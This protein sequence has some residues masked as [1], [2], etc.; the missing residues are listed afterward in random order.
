M[1]L[2]ASLKQTSKLST[3]P[4]FEGAPLSMKAS[5]LACEQFALSNHLSDAATQQLTELIRMHCPS[6]EHCAKSTYQLRNQLKFNLEVESK[7]FCS[8]CKEEINEVSKM[9]SKSKCK[10][11]N[12]GVCYLAVL[13]FHSHLH[14]IFTGKIF[15]LCCIIFSCFFFT[16][17]WQEIC[18]HFES[19]QHERTTINDIHN[20]EVFRSLRGEGKFLCVPEH[21]GLILSCDGVP[22][23]KSS[24][25]T[26]YNVFNIFISVTPTTGQSFWPVLIS[27]TSLPPDIRYN[28]E[29]TMTA[30]LWLGPCKPPMKLILPPVL[31][32]I[33]KLENNGMEL[34]TP[35]G[36][37]IL[38]AKLLVGV[39]DFPAKAMALNIVQFNGY[40]GCPYCLDKGVYRSHRLLYLPN[41]KHQLRKQREIINWAMQ[42]ERRN[43]PVYGI[44]GVSILAKHITQKRVPTD[45]MHAVSEGTTKQFLKCWTDPK[46]KHLKFYIGNRVKEIDKMLLRIKPPHEFQRSPRPI[47]VSHFWKASEY[48]SWLLYYSL[49]ILKDILPPDYVHHFALLVSSMHILLGTNLSV[50]LINDAERML[51][52]FYNLMPELYP[53]TMCTPNV[54]SLIHLCTSVRQLGPLW[55]YSCFGFENMNGVIKRDQHGCR[56]FLPSLT[57][58]ICMKISLSLHKNALMISNQESDKTKRFFE[59]RSHN[60][61]ED[62]PVGKI[63]TITLNESERQILR[64]A[65]LTIPENGLKSCN[66]YMLKQTSY[67]ARKNPMKLRDSSVC[68]FQVGP[69]TMMGSIRKFVFLNEEPTA[70]I[71]IFETVEENLLQAAHV[72]ARRPCYANNTF[73][74]EC[75]KKVKKI[76]VSNKA[77]AVRVKAIHQK[78]VHI[79]VKH[80]DIDVIVKQP[81]IYEHH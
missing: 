47:S 75:F 78:C 11:K 14:T 54:H 48:R 27:V 71:D 61:F 26:Y 49:P 31:S 35:Q 32:I 23:F 56:N 69:N 37:K 22:A 33:S 80:S 52:E 9:C 44:K 51:L 38:K 46:N 42:A 29:Y 4:L 73:I 81:N 2:P 43:E 50:E 76:S 65:G 21:T 1:L 55:A 67:Q 58:A 34:L 45:Y 36:P 40:Y 12:S 10:S 15:I 20:G 19:L 59:K 41:D 70:I 17:K 53:E 74:N 72:R 16:E 6:D 62:G 64:N 24:G 25:M 18:T 66:S 7:A 63:K 13:P 3:V 5:W 28:A 79:P 30:A 39:F 60:Y 68:M 77:V 57:N 8:L